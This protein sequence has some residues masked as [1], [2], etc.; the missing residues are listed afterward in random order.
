MIT[1]VFKGLSDIYGTFA[2]ME[3]DRLII[4]E[5]RVNSTVYTYQGSI[6]AF[7]N[8][9]DYLKLAA[10]NR[11]LLDD[12]NDYY[13]LWKHDKNKQEDT[14]MNNT[15]ALIERLT[16]HS[17][18]YYKQKTQDFEQVAKDCLAAAD[19][20]YMYSNSEITGKLSAGT[21]IEGRS[22]RTTKLCEIK[23]TEGADSLKELVFQLTANGYR[24]DVAP[25]YK[26]FPKTGL[27]YWMIAIFDR[28]EKK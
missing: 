11:P 25:V 26:E 19:K 7:R 15:E 22:N 27:D 8:S 3:N 20:L 1:H 14:A 23:V 21:G 2:Y 5:N 12:I 10:R 18:D 16:K 4:G 13:S 6:E 9:R 28:E 24:V 17:D